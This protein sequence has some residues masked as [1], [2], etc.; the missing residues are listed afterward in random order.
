MKINKWYLC[1]GEY[2]GSVVEELE[3]EDKEKLKVKNV[4][5]L[6]LYPQ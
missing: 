3:L 6:I 5:I 1:L 4:M 2:F